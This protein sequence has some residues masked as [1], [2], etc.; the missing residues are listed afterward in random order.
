MFFLLSFTENTTVQL[1][2]ISISNTSIIYKLIPLFFSYISLEFAICINHK[3]EAMRLLKTISLK[4]YNQKVDE[5]YFNILNTLNPLTRLVL[6]YS[7]WSDF[8]NVLSQK[9]N[10][11]TGCLGV[12]LF[13]PLLMIYLLPFY[14]EFICI[15][16]LVINYWSD[17]IAK[18]SILIST[19]LSLLTIYFYLEVAYQN[20]KAL[21]AESAL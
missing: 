19:W 3:G 7:F 15:K 12:I 13:F 6:P 18:T 1:G 20:K 21:K 14:F 2:P 11:F 4:I 17:W 16:F 8:G 10:I 9:K 5:K